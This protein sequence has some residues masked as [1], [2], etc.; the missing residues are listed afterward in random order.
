VIYPE[1]SQEISIQDHQEYNTKMSGNIPKIHYFPISARAEF[2][3]LLWEDTKTPY[4]FVKVPFGEHVKNDK[5]PFGQLPV[6]EADGLMLAESATITRYVAK[7]V[8]LYPSDAKEA[9][10]AGKNIP[11]FRFDKSEMMLDAA[12]DLYDLLVSVVLTKL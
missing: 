7:K 11:C 6:L 4:E 2:V 3:R 1:V 12:N 9:A 10:I 8:G 5:F